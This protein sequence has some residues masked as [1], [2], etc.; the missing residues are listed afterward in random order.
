MCRI[1]K[2]YPANYSIFKEP[3]TMQRLPNVTQTIVIVISLAWLVASSACAADSPEKK[4]ALMKQ[5]CPKPTE[6]ALV[7]SFGYAGDGMPKDDAKFEG[8]LKKIKEHGFNVI[9][10]SYTDKRLELCKKHGVKLMVDLLDIENHHVYKS[11]DKAK[12]LAA[13]LKGNPAVWGYNIWNDHTR[14]REAGRERD[15]NTVRKWDPTHPAYSGG[16]ANDNTRVYTTADVMGYYDFHW[17]RGIHLHFPHLLLFLEGSRKHDSYPYTWLSWRP[18]KYSDH[19]HRSL[20]SANTTIACGFKGIMWFLGSGFMDKNSL[21][22]K[23]GKMHVLKVHKEIVPVLGE[24]MKLG[25][26]TAV[27][28][29]KITKTNENKPL[30][31][32]KKEMM[33][34]GLE[35]R[36]FAKDFWIQPQSG[37]FVMGVYKD[38]KKRDAIFVANHNSQAPQ[39]VKL[40]LGKPVKASMF[41]RKEGK[42]QNLAVKDGSVSFELGKAA[43]ELLRFEG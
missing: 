20:W 35:N 26:P 6:F 18:F 16:C 36:G 5:R 14:G 24:M 31:G 13:K 30:P 2:I 42:W 28:S 9:H 27:Y 7:F 38:D 37:E 8:L 15:I 33:P 23:P 19:Y 10:T 32:G 11:A 34:P 29:T 21:E 25:L 43:G 39:T 12:A 4:A 40:K 3:T 17:E 22:W 41:N 1:F